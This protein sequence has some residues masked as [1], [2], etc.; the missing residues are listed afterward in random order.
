MIVEIS[1]AL[2]KQIENHCNREFDNVKTNKFIEEALKEIVEIVPT[3]EEK[4]KWKQYLYERLM[5]LATE[6]PEFRPR[7]KD[8][9]NT[10][11][12]SFLHWVEEYNDGYFNEREE[13]DND[14]YCA[15]LVQEYDR[16]AIV[17]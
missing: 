10:L 9:L 2:Y 17:F 4:S 12:E 1:D 5:F 15:W 11:L 13:A 8:N 3:R 16:Y 6:R 14:K 7:K